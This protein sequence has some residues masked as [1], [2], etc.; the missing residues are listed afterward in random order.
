MH[1]YKSAAIAVF[2]YNR[3]KHLKKLLQSILRNQISR[4]LEIFIFIDGLKEH[5]NG[6]AN[7][8]TLEE[9]INFQKSHGHTQIVRR[10]AN[11]GLSSSIISGINEIFEIKEH[12]IVLEDDLVC[13]NYFLDF[14]LEGLSEFE[15]VDE[16]ASIH[17]YL[18][19]L[20]RIF[21]SPN[22][23]RGADC[24][25]WAS[26]K[27]RWQ[28][29]EWDSKKL[30]KQLEEQNLLFEFD[31]GG[32]FPFSTMLKQQAD[33]EIDSWAIR[34]HASMFL[35]SRL[36]LYPNYSLIGNEG[37]DNSGTHG[38]TSNAYSTEIS[39]NRI[40]IPKSIQIEE[41]NMFQEAMGDFY[42]TL[43]NQKEPIIYKLRRK[44]HSYFSPFRHKN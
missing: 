17:G 10:K 6:E 9:A 18:P 4:N 42:F 21:E 31:F 14:C 12:I 33:Q 2:G 13:S 15:N 22:F 30:L 35:Q 38:K 7:A 3:P 29:V 34:W 8:R 32:K 1:K 39:R 44:I 5:E 25:G 16:V 43:A 28:S 11:L 37:F 24:W 36:T 40:K 27:N 20:N 26:W 41:N 19:P 23:L